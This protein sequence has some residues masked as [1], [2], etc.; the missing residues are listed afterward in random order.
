[1]QPR[2]IKE[3][4]SPDIN[5]KP[6]TMVGLGSLEQLMDFQCCLGFSFLFWGFL[7]GKLSMLHSFLEKINWSFKRWFSRSQRRPVMA[8]FACHSGS[9]MKNVINTFLVLGDAG[10]FYSRHCH[11]SIPSSQLPDH[12]I[13]VDTEV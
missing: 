12:I 4:W 3:I 9:Q 10:G 8:V 6:A 2:Y 1:M 7:S 11:V 13:H 5:I